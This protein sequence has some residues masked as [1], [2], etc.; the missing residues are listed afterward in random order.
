MARHDLLRERDAR[1]EVTAG[2]AACD[3]HLHAVTSRLHLC[4]GPRPGS[5]AP[6]PARLRVALSDSSTPAAAIIITSEVP[7]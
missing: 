4:P 3:E 1:E 7:P 2:A 5:R 6:G